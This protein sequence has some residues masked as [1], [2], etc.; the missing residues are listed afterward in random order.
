MGKT[1]V[2][3]SYIVFRRLPVIVW[4]FL[5]NKVLSFWQTFLY[6]HGYTQGRELNISEIMIIILFRISRF[7]LES[8]IF[9]ESNHRFPSTVPW[10]VKTPHLIELK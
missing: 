9:F 5:R 1:A 10:P 4:R 7:F 2:K 8:R 6:R 3:Y